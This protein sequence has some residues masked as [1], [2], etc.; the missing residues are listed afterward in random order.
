MNPPR[1]SL[2][3]ENSAK[4][5]FRRKNS[6]VE[7][8]WRFST[9]SELFAMIVSATPINPSVFA[10]IVES[11]KIVHSSNR[12]SIGS[13]ERNTFGALGAVSSTCGSTDSALRNSSDSPVWN[14]QMYRIHC[15]SNDC[16]FSRGELKA[17]L[18]L[19]AIW[20]MNLAS[21]S[22]SSML[23]PESC[24]IPEPAATR[25]STKVWFNKS[26]TFGSP[27]DVHSWSKI[28]G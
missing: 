8:R 20:S 18:F 24:F 17:A 11:R 6:C 25:S 15:T 4:F 14:P 28:L 19:I 3:S 27:L 12:V 22:A 7:F 1:T 5:C 16:M 9:S 13:P 21:T 23:D 2:R 10:F 26:T